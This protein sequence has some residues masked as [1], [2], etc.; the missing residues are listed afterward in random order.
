MTS[1][2]GGAPY[3]RIPSGYWLDF[4]RLAAEY[5]WQTPGALRRWRTYYPDTD[6]WHFQKTDGLSW[7]DTMLEV[8]REDEIEAVF[9]TQ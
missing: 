6:W 9:G 1:V 4:T 8:Y 7:L 3:A 2:F 5:G